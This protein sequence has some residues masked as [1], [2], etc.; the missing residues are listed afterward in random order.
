MNDTYETGLLQITNGRVEYRHTTGE[1]S[2][3]RLEIAGIGTRQIR[4]ANL[5]PGTSERTLRMALAPYEEIVTL[6]DELWSRMYRYKVANGIKVATMKLTKHLPSHMSIAG[7][8][9]FS[10]L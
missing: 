7:L 2:I 3:V 4:I 8:R 6:Q 9:A 10:V 5:P 1:I